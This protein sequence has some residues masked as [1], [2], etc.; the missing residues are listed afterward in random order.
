MYY[1]L[2]IYYVSIPIRTFYG[3]TSLEEEVAALR[4]QSECTRCA[5]PEVQVASLKKEVEDLQ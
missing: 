1:I 4:S 5:L 2:P 3:C